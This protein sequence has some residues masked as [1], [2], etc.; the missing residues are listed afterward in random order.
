MIYSDLYAGVI[1]DDMSLN[2]H[3]CVDMHAPTHFTKNSSL[4]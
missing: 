4:N 3:R 1:D 2:M